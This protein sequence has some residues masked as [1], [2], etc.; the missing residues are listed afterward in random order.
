VSEL[1]AMVNFSDEADNHEQFGSQGKHGGSQVQIDQ[2]A[3]KAMDKFS[4]PANAHL[5]NGSGLVLD[6]SHAQIGQMMSESM[7]NFMTL[8]HT[9]ISPRGEDMDVS[10]TPTKGAGSGH[11][12]NDGMIVDLATLEIELADLT[13][14]DRMKKSSESQRQSQLLTMPDLQVA[15]HEQ[16]PRTTGVSRMQHRSPE[17]PRAGNTI[18]PLVRNSGTPTTTSHKFLERALLHPNDLLRSFNAQ[19]WQPHPE[20]KLVHINVSR[21]FSSIRPFAYRSNRPK[22]AEAR[23]QSLLYQLWPNRSKFSL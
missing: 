6:E 21:F 2:V 22:T 5:K 20:L 17:M 7:S 14:D 9:Q 11:G 15:S 18:I 3:I 12:G 13:L 8:D 23:G 19:Q 10:N 16:V 1:K 4:L